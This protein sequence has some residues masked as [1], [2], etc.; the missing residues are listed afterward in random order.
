[1]ASGGSLPVITGSYVA[2][3]AE[4][5]IEVGFRPKYIKFTN[6]TTGASAEYHDTIRSSRTTRGPTTR[7][8]QTA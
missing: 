7:R 2:S 4:Q 5:D 3:G 6:T 8:P 1:M